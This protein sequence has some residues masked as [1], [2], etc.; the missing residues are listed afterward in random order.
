MQ[1]TVASESYSAKA[2]F[3]QQTCAKG[4]NPLE[5]MTLQIRVIVSKTAPYELSKPF[6]CAFRVLFGSTVDLATIRYY[7]NGSLDL[8]PTG[9]CLT[10]ET[11]RY[12]SGGL[13]SLVLRGTSGNVQWKTAAVVAVQQAA[14]SEKYCYCPGRLGHP[15][16]SSYFNNHIH[17]GYDTECM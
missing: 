13:G 15:K 14:V 17:S 10:S 1:Y 16:T 7:L 3:P 12:K 6:L 5:T 11:N 9:G 4:P 2:S 8:H